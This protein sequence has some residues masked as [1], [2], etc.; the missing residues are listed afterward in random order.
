[1]EKVLIKQVCSSTIE[2]NDGTQIYDQD[3]LI[4]LIYL[5]YLIFR[6]YDHQSTQFDFDR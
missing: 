6:I 4:I 1:M 2:S 3:P 5:D